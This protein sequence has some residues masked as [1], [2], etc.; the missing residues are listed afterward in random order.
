MEQWLIPALLV[1]VTNVLGLYTGGR[2]AKASA[3][4]DEAAAEHNKASAA[5][6]I[7]DSAVD[8]VE[9]YKQGFN[10]L[11]AELKGVKA[12][13]AYLRAGMEINIQ[14]MR[15]AGIEPKFIP[16]PGKVFYVP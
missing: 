13:L 1:F 6:A 12:E 2:A 9:M 11:Q 16:E 8:I 3:K 7:T 14:Q 4:K 5:G 10:T 15:D